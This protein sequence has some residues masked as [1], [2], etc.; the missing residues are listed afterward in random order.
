MAEEGRP[1]K[2]KHRFVFGA[3]ERQSIPVGKTKPAGWLVIEDKTGAFPASAML[4]DM[5]RSFRC[6]AWLLS[7]KTKVGEGARCLPLYRENCTVFFFYYYQVHM[8][9]DTINMCLGHMTTSS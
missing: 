8:L 5:F 7:I 1:L 3:S 4:V 2:S 6:A 9:R